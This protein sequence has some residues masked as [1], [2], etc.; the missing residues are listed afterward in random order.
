MKGQDA[1]NDLLSRTKAIVET[2]VDGVITISDRGLIETV[3]PAVEKIFGYRLDELSGQNVSMLMP[4]PY[5]REHDSYLS[6]YLSTGEKKIIGIGREV[7]GRRKD[8]S[9]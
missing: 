6:N 9:T 4:N 2:I 1:V 8:G 3:N 5:Q 7:T